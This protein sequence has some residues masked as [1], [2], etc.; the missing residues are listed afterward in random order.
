VPWGS[1]G[2]HFWGRSERELSNVESPWPRCP[3]R[4]GHSSRLVIIEYQDADDV[5]SH[6]TS[7]TGAAKLLWTRFWKTNVY[8][9][10][11][12]SVCNMCAITTPWIVYMSAITNSSR[13]SL[14]YVCKHHDVPSVRLC[15]CA[16]VESMRLT[17]RDVMNMGSGGCELSRC[18][19]TEHVSY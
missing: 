16:A 1:F 11:R 10:Y 3:G 13:L 19:C 9:S 8:Q 17:C 2:V 4:P 7:G 14:E 6:N 15:C 12:D 18:R 5:Q